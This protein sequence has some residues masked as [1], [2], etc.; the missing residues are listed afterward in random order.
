MPKCRE[1]SCKEMLAD[2][3]VAD[4][5]VADGVDPDDLQALLRRVATRRRIAT[6]SDGRRQ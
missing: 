2:P 1:L 4:L 5:M 6:G 3:I